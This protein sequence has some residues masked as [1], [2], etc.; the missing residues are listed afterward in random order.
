MPYAMVEIEA[1]FN[2]MQAHKKEL[3]D[4][5]K[6]LDTMI[7]KVPEDFK[8]SYEKAR[9]QLDICIKQYDPKEN[10]LQTSY[11]SVKTNHQTISAI[12]PKKV[13]KKMFTAPMRTLNALQEAI[14]E[15]LRLDGA[16]KENY[17]ECKD[18]KNKSIY[19]LEQIRKLPGLSEVSLKS[20]QPAPE[21]KRA[22]ELSSLP[23]P[24]R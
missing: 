19:L 1:K 5:R 10:N 24:R 22:S 6:A 11:N 15:K 20:E 3:D 21:E 2:E 8:K 13:M 9:Q 23:K 18:L 16:F 12:K 17:Q 14:K 7:E 4:L